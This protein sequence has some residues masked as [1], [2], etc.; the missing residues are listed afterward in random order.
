MCNCYRYV[1]LCLRVHS[2]DCESFFSLFFLL[3]EFFV[4]L[5]PT[6]MHSGTHRQC[7]KSTLCMQER[8]SV[9]LWVFVLFLVFVPFRLIYAYMHERKQI[10]F[11]ICCYFILLF[12][13]RYNFCT[14]FFRILHFLLCSA[15]YICER[16]FSRFLLFFFGGVCSIIPYIFFV[17]A[18]GTNLL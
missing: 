9:M 2:E 6:K 18:V 17:L 11:R 15:L 13:G 5:V 3:F 7:N 1:Y 8:E 12:S 14:C 4:G 16:F 10:L